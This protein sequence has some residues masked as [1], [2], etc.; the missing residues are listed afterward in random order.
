VDRLVPREAPAC[1]HRLGIARQCAQCRHGVDKIANKLQIPSEKVFNFM[2]NT[3]NTVSSSIPIALSE[4]IKSG[5]AKKG[6]TI[7]LAGF[8]VGLSWAA[9]IIK[10]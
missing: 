7:L 8:G 5:N 9:T 2:K 10:L 1:S 3:G 6:D 4:A